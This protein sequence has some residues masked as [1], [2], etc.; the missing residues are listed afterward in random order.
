M[1]ADTRIELVLMHVHCTL[2]RK[3]LLRNFMMRFQ[4]AANTCQN[5]ATYH[6]FVIQAIQNLRTKLA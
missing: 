5:I 1:I 4:L 3:L 2:Q 6:F